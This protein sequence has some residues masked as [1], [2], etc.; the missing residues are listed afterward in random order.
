MDKKR[1]CPHSRKHLTLSG[2]EEGR[3]IG[4]TQ[5]RYCPPVSLSYGH[6]SIGCTECIAYRESSSGLMQLN[7]APPGF[8]IYLSVPR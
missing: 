4:N 5:T 8:V 7:V 6:G 3:L 1:A 2:Q